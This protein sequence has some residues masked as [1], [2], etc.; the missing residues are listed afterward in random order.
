MQLNINKLCSVGRQLNVLCR[1]KPLLL[2]IVSSKL[3]DGF[4]L[5]VT[6]SCTVEELKELICE[7]EG[8]APNCQCL[9]FGKQQ[10][11]Q[12]MPL[13]ELGIETGVTV[14]LLTIKPKACNKYTEDIG[15]AEYHPLCQTCG[16]DYDDHKPC[17]KSAVDIGCVEPCDTCGL[18]AM[19][20]KDCPDLPWYEVNIPRPPSSSHER[21]W[22]DMD[23]YASTHSA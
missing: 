16:V 3:S 7:Q 13:C 9:V 11:V 15:V 1:T 14:T 17:D 22:C 19:D 20:H 10:L 23:L 21:V 2:E 18:E 12:G 8:I 4:K 6:D 5:E